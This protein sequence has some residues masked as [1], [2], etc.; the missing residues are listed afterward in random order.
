MRHDCAG[1]VFRQA[2]AIGGLVAV[3]LG[4]LFVGP[5]AAGGP[6]APLLG[7]TGSGVGLVLLTESGEVAQVVV[8]EARRLVT[9]DAVWSPDGTRIAFTSPRDDVGRDVWVVNADG[10]GLH[11]VTS[12]GAVNRYDTIPVWISATELAYHHRDDSTGRTELRAIDLTTSTARL[13][14]AEA[15]ANFRPL[16]QPGGSMLVYTTHAAEHR[17]IVDVRT[18]ER[19]SLPPDV[20]DAVA[21]APDGSRLAY[22]TP[23][24]MFVIRPDGSDRRTLVADHNVRS[25]DWSR[26][27]RRLAFTIAD[28]LTY[29]KFG[30]AALSNVYTVD[31]DGS[32]LRRLTGVDGD[33]PFTADPADSGAQWWPGGFQLF[34]TT[35]R[36]PG[37]VQTIW[38]MN[39]DGSCE[40]PWSDTALRGVPSW[41]PGATDGASP[42]VSCNAVIVRVRPTEGVALRQR[43]HIPVQIENDGTEPLTNLR[44]DISSNRGV[45]DAPEGCNDRNCIVA[46]LAPGERWSVSIPV[47]ARTAGTMRVRIRARYDGGH[48]VFPADDGGTAL[49]DVWPCDLLGSTGAD[50]LIGTAR[51]ELICGRAGDDRIEGRGGNDQ[52]DAGGADDTVVGGAGDDRIEGRAGNDRIDA[53]PAD[54]TVVGGTGDDRIIAGSG[55]DVVFVRDRRRDVVDCG[56]GR[57]TVVADAADVITSTCETVVRG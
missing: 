45:V 2:L 38:T 49:V 27:G 14:V 25:V 32:N 34:F 13:L 20:R 56:A 35:V 37:Y 16:L 50:R 10:T 6:T 19:H 40:Q 5:S 53:G 26:D 11:A 22:G 1:H 54:D 8:P 9:V 29:T 18:G 42:D 46:S 44:L 15:D 39:A 3:V 31:A 28:I 33:S 43:A 21:W 41:R 30:A 51:A 24:G 17:A 7:V 47:W 12:D 57:D 36:P 48:D 55:R 52:I 4:L 23:S